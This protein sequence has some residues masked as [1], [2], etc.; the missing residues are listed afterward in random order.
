VP[1]AV[2]SGQ[3]AGFLA[4]EGEGARSVRGELDRLAYNLAFEVN[5]VHTTG[6][7]RSGSFS[8]LSSF[9]AVAD[10]DGDGQRG[11]ELLSQADLPF[12]ITSGELFVTITNR[13]TGEIERSRIDIDPSAMTLDD[14]ADAMTRIPHV[15]ASVDPT[16]RFRV[17]AES[18]YGFDFGNR[19]DSTP[20]S[21]GSFGGTAP[22]IASTDIGPFDLGTALG[23]P[24][25]TFTAVIDG[26]SVAITLTPGEFL[27]QS[28]VTVAELVTAINT[29]L[30]TTGKAAN[31]GGRLVIRSNSSGSS[32]TLALTDGA[33]SPLATLGLATG[34]TRSG[35]DQGVSPKISGTYTGSSNGQFVFVPDADGQIGVTPG[36]TVSVFDAQGVK[37]AT[38]DVGSTYSPNST[39]EVGDGISVSF[40]PG[41]VSSSFQDVFAVDTIHDSD[42]S[43]VLV[44]LGLNSFFHGTTASDLSVNTDIETNPDL[45][46]AGLSGAPGDAANLARLTDLRGTDIS[47]LDDKSIEDFYSGIVGSVGF[48][49]ASAQ[50]FL[51]AQDALLHSIQEQ[52]DSVSGVNIDEESVDMLRYQQAFEA[53]SRFVSV[54]TDITETLMNI[55]R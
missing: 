50:H 53:A 35:Q 48:D 44:A 1:L 33:G 49:S 23:S 39:L 43:D 47:A 6:V 9:Y 10:T 7:P 16:G 19:L 52:R 54:V 8:G 18:G 29:D 38:L 46:A 12:P 41:T 14:L 42:T 37:V 28:S 22:S 36:L 25:A 5:R 34:A 26:N 13:A 4:N 30:G 17:N 31:V 55:A 2:H 45:L 21:F 40:G 3:I 11:D 51:D 27:D 20:D 15:S 24:P 32:A